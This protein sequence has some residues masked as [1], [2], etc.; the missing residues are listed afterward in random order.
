MQNLWARNPIT[1]EYDYVNMGVITRE[2]YV[3]S[4]LIRNE[5][6]LKNP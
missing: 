5:D 2:D 3:K 4:L 1:I 6:N